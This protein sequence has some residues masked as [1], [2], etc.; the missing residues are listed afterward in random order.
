MSAQITQLQS[1][2]DR[3]NTSQ[4]KDFIDNLKKKLAN[5]NSQE[6]RNFL[7][8]C[9][10]T[11]NSELRSGGNK[12]PQSGG[13]TVAQGQTKFCPN[14]G[15]N[16]SGNTSPFCPECGTNT[17]ARGTAQALQN[18]TAPGKYFLL[19]PAILSIVFSLVVL[20]QSANWLATMD[21]WL[22][23]FGGQAMREAWLIHYWGR[24]ALSIFGIYVSIMCI[25]HC[26][27]VTKGGK[28]QNLG[29]QYVVFIIA[30]QASSFIWGPLNFS[31]LH[32]INLILMLIDY[33]A[34][35]L[36]LVGAHKNI[37]AI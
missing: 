32:G 31:D 13:R 27:D 20:I 34:P 26:S 30:V 28:L 3:L 33:I 23:Q 17:V 11:Y 7:N 10:A 9:V 21:T 6:W 8:R 36:I 24:V 12:A 2:F 15:H 29:I 16:F 25:V 5:N 4:K 14:C 37:K 1:H 35:A 22:W 18:S 19:V